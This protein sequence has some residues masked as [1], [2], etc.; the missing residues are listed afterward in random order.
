MTVFRDLFDC[1]VLSAV[2]LESAMASTHGGPVEAQT[3]WDDFPAS[4]RYGNI[5]LLTLIALRLLMCQT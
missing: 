2:L 4:D 1:G 3:F 5:F